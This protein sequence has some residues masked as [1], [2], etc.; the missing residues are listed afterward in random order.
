[1]RVTREA[2][3]EIAEAAAVHEVHV[4]NP[5]IADVDVGDKSPA[6]MPPR[7]ERFAIAQREPAHAAAKPKAAATVEPYE[8]RSVE[9]PAKT[10]TR[11]PAPASAKI[12]P[13]A[14]VERRKSPRVIVNPRPAPGTHPAP[15]APAI[16]RPADGNDARIPYCA[17]IRNL[18]PRAVIVQIVV[19]GNVAGNVLRGNGIVFLQVALLRPAIE[20]VRFGRGADA[21]LNV[22]GSVEF[23]AFARM[24]VV[25]LS[26]CSDF[27]FAT[28][29]GDAA[30]IAIFVHVNAECARLLHGE[31]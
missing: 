8:S 31:S 11:A 4:A 19:A 9:R 2:V 3:V 27:A 22:L 17:V 15:I 1:M 18:A 20:T 29:H 12:I 26:A 7:T 5:R 13:P 28:N 14:V 6:R 24:N 30:G 23:A 21:V 10:R 25:G 16:R